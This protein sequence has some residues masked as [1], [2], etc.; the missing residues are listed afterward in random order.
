MELV[1]DFLKEPGQQKLWVAL[2]AANAGILIGLVFY[3]ISREPPVIQYSYLLVTYH[4]GFVKRALLG[5]IVALFRPTLAMTDVWVI[6]TGVWLLTIGLFVA[7]FAR[8]FGWR[9]D[10]IQLFVFTFGSPFFFK[11]FFHTAG[12]F[13]I[14][15]CLLALAALLIPAGPAYPFVIAAGC[16][17]ALLIHHLHFLLYLP[18]VGFVVLIRFYV[19]RAS[20]TF[21][22]VVGAVLGALVV[23]VFFFIL[24]F[25]NAPVPPETFLAYMQSHASDPLGE[26]NMTVWYS[27]VDEEFAQTAAMFPSNALRFPIYAALIALHWPVAAFMRA[28]ILSIPERSRRLLAIAGLAGITL[29]YIP[30]FIFVFDYARWVSN[31]GVCMILAL[32]AIALLCPRNA[33]PPF[34]KPDQAIWF[35]ILG[36]AV[37]LIPRVALVMAFNY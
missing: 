5:T 23:S 3:K 37:T 14:Y 6:A 2:A 36:L 8:T 26:V 13:D 27:T 10:R 7:L 17:I 22:V 33:M 24:A 30:I 28:L 31:W 18:L 35:L 9:G 4:F 34:A 25:G 29:A 1:R 20:S 32:H 11:N 16:V 15:G 12:F 21:N 19:L